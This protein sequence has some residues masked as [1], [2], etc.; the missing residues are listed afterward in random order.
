M[1]LD[2]ATSAEVLCLRTSGSFVEL[3]LGGYGDDRNALK[4]AD[5]Q[6]ISVFKRIA[7]S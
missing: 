6:F 5:A 1:L 7:G 3:L 4:A 2:P